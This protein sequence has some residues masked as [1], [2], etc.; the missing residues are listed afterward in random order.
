VTPRY[1]CS[2]STTASSCTS[3][4]LINLNTWVN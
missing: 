2:M 4:I 3:F 1:D